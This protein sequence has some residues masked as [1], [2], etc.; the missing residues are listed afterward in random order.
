MST[1]V[2]ILAERL[3]R[4]QATQAQQ[5]VE[6]SQAATLA[7]AATAASQTYMVNPMTTA[8]DLIVGGTGGAATRLPAGSDGQILAM[9]GGS[10]TWA[11]A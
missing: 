8:E 4:L 6:V 9:S 3:A 2:S 10:V 5:R 7:R 1:D 11:P